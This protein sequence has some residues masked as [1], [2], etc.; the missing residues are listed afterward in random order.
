MQY[1]LADVSL[2][3]PELSNDFLRYGFPRL[4]IGS[5]PEAQLIQADLQVGFL[6]NIV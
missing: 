4:L 6:V 3:A 1:I 2:E 5:S